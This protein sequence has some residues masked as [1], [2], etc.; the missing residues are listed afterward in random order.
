MNPGVVKI[1]NTDTTPQPAKKEETSLVVEAGTKVLSIGSTQPTS[2]KKATQPAADTTAAAPPKA[3][4]P[5]RAAGKSSPAPSSG[6]SSPARQATESRKADAVAQEQSADVDEQTLKEIYGK[7]HMNVI[8]I[9]H[10]DAGKST[11]GGCIL[12]NTG[13]VDQRTLEKYKKEAKDMGRESVGHS[14]RRNFNF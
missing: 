12:V 2:A 6:R 5:K 1:T 14:L 4:A 7:E 8:F 11:L 9:G 3:A 10:V 13:M